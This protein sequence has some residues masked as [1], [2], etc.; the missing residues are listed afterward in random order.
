VANDFDQHVPVLCDQ[1]AE[2]LAVQPGE[3]V[4]DCTVGL[5]GHARM[6]AEPIGGEGLLIGTDVDE[7]NLDLA[8]RRLE[9]CGC[10]HR[11]FRCNF[12]EMDE[13]LAA[14]AIDAVDVVLA[15]IGVSSSQLADGRRG[16]SFQIEGPLD[17]RMDDRLPETASDLVNRLA[18]SDLADLIYRY[19]QERYSRRIA[20]AIHYARFRERISTTTRLAEVVAGALKVDPA[21]RAAKIHP[22]TRTF[23]ALRIAVNDELGALQRLLEKAPRYLSPG[24]RIGVI[25]FHSLED[26][27]VKE[28]FRRRK[29]DEIY[30]LLTKKPVTATVEEI[31]KNPRSR[32][33]KFRVAV[34]TNKP[35]GV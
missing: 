20:R 29:S 4:L 18:E 26:G 14:A 6:L 32:S 3:V 7:S 24:G 5:G 9:G 10:P 13:A 1:V 35:I 31:K 33:A 22:A 15:D 8:A 25:S 17:M 2:L 11:L 23:Q 19:G 28:D 21:S 34:R 27:I 16:F 30:T 12:G